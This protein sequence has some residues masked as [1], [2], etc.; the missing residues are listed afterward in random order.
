VPIGLSRK[1]ADDQAAL[2]GAL[3][4]HYLFMSALP[5]MVSLAWILGRLTAHDPE[6][7][8]RVTDGLAGQL[9]VLGDQLRHASLQG[10]PVGLAVGLAF[11]VFAG[12]AV[13][14]VT[15]NASNTAWGIP[16]RDR[17]G[18]LAAR[19]RSLAIVAVIGSLVV[20]WTVLGG[21][22]SWISDVPVVGRLLGF[23]AALAALTVVVAAFF[24]A[25]TPRQMAHWWKHWP[26]ALA[27]ATGWTVL[28]LI[29]GAF[30]SHQVLHWGPV[31]GTFALVIALLAWLA[32]VGQV[33]VTGIEL[34]VVLHLRLYPRALTGT[35][36]GA[37]RRAAE[38]TV[39]AALPAVMPVELVASDVASE[40][41]PASGSPTG[42]APTM[43]R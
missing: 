32:L 19:V 13:L 22:A 37:D 15:Q 42:S 28:Q 9:P 20:V 3:V 41:E 34:N 14:V 10:S 4:G 36:S 23:G 8:K 1:R 21:I 7:R 30:I 25:L 24:A 31:Y 12:L 27:T 29:A 35:P 43:W 18:G 33:T 6:L 11:A 2:L 5:L 38:L 39:A 40:G 17:P 16:R 26:G